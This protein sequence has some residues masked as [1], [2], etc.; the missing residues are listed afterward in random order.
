[1]SKDEI[2]YVVISDNLDDLAWICVLVGWLWL[3]E[4]TYKCLLSRLYVKSESWTKLGE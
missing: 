2:A 4:P 1:M 3:V